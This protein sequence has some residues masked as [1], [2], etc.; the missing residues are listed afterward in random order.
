MTDAMT[1]TQSLGRCNIAVGL[2][3]PN[4]DNPNAMTDSEFNLLYD[5]ISQVG[6]TDPILVRVHPDNK[7]KYRI[8]GGEHRWEVAKLIGFSE[9]PCTVITDKDFSEDQERFQLVRHNI[10]HGKMSPQKFI[11]LY[12][13]LSEKY[14][15]EVASEMFGFVEEDEFKKLINSTAKVLPKDIQKDFKD[16]AK[17]LKT[18]DGLAALLNKMFNEYGDDLAYGYM[19][20]DFGGK[21]SIWLR[22]LPGMKK[23]FLGIAK[24]C[25]D[26]DK[27]VDQFMAG[28]MQLLATNKLHDFKLDKFL[29]TLP[30]VI[31]AENVEIPSLDFL[32]EL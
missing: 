30:E 2:L 4:P 29:E 14:S 24:T 16:A 20:F 32:D 31:L 22:L 11:K 21:E 9:V 12:E 18:I 25:K 7:D 5:N 19:I 23:H 27:T 13:G 28:I 3:E 6:I 17:E 1:K 8:I 10:I 15:D 26:N